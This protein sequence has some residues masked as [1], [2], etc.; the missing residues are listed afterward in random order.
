LFVLQVICLINTLKLLQ[1]CHTTKQQAGKEREVHKSVEEPL[2]DKENEMSGVL[3]KSKSVP[4]RAPVDVMK[5]VL[6]EFFRGEFPKFRYSYAWV[7][8]SERVW[9]HFRTGL[10]NTLDV[11]HEQ[12][13]GDGGTLLNKAGD[14]EEASMSLGET[15]AANPELQYRLSV[16]QE[17]DSGERD[18]FRRLGE[19]DK[20]GAGTSS[21]V[22]KQ[23]QQQPPPEP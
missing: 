15:G 2:Q 18:E 8:E 7:L 6:N 3:A 12:M 11:I 19:C 4:T 16:G 5:H 1:K 10:D 20:H 9:P 13:A 22:P 14:R 23:P 17:T 21:A